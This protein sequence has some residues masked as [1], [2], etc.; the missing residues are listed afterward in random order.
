MAFRSDG[1]PLEP[2][3]PLARFLLPTRS[4]LTKTTLT[5]LLALAASLPAQDAAPS[6]PVPSAVT[7]PAAEPAA[8]PPAAEPAKKGWSATLKEKRLDKEAAAVSPSQALGKTFLGLAFILG[9][10]AAMAWA[11]RRWGRRLGVAPGQGEMRI[12]GRITLDAKNSLV[13]VR[14]HEEELLLAVGPN[15]TTS[16]ARYA[17]IDHENDLPSIG[18]AQRQRLP[19]DGPGSSEKSDKDL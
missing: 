7:S 4:M 14:V 11:L 12:N 8:T 6:S 9:L 13:L 10:I 1:D 16:L 17:L 18:D 15:G 2:D 19:V 3:F 5:L